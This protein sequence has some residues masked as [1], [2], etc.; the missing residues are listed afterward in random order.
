MTGDPAVV[1]PWWGAAVAATALLLGVGLAW[2]ISAHAGGPVR[3]WVLGLLGGA[4]LLLLL[5]TL[6]RW[7]TGPGDVP[8][9]LW[10]VGGLL[11]L[12]AGLAVYPDDR[13]PTG[14]GPLVLVPLLAPGLLALTYPTVYA[15]NGLAGLIEFLLLGCLIWWRYEHASPVER[16]PL[17]WLVLGGGSLTLLGSL[18]GF[19]VTPWVTMVV[20]SLLSV[21]AVGCLVAGLVAP[22]RWDVRAATVGT[23]VHVVTALTL[24]AA[25]T[26]ALSAIELATGRPVTSPGS[27]GLLA[28]LLAAGYH[29]MARL[30]RGVT[31]LMLFG[32]RR[33]PLETVSRVGERL[34]EGP[35]RALAS[36]RESLAL[37]YA[38]IRDEAGA[39]VAASGAPTPRVVELSLLPA[40]AKLGVLVIG[41]RPGE[42]ALAGRDREVLAVVGP[43]LAQ[44]MRARAL[45]EALAVS[46]TEV[47]LAVEEERRRLRRDLHDG[48]GP[49]LTGVAYTADAAR[50][51]L[52]DPVRTEELLG[53][54]RADA[55]DAI[56]E[57]RRLVEGLRPPTLDQVGLVEALRQH[58]Q[59]LHGPEGRPMTVRLETEEPLGPLG[60]G[61]EV[62]AYRIAVEA[63]TNAARHSGGT[64]CEVRLQRQNGALVVEVADDGPRREG[65]W[66]PGVGLSSMRERTE[67]LGGTLTAGGGRVRATLPL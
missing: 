58:G 1:T 47:V 56:A 52:P 33:P 25:Y 45:G 44:L 32:E 7:T 19:A 54:L 36:L 49:R 55:A 67:L 13:L 29:P 2:W 35:E 57:V 31:D 20:I 60:A 63:L 46:R 5:A 22:E 21:G 30:L 28:A 34:G 61:V 9:A 53:M 11:L 8:Q 14:L 38:A 42:V 24:V 64:T 16:R 10:I 48:L 39:V 18:A 66:R 26:T 27:L 6:L 37:P 40:D 50:N 3:R 51:S 17:L 12:P 15:V 4:G 43:A 23:V 59:A 41:L 62:A 65:A